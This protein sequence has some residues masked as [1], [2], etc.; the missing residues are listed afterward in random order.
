MTTATNSPD[1]E[2]TTPLSRADVAD[3]LGPEAVIEGICHYTGERSQ[4]GYLLTKFLVSMRDS[5]NRSEFERAPE[6]YMV[7]CG[8][9]DIEREMISL[10]DYDGMLEYGASIY[11]LGKASGALGTT[12]LEIGAKSRQQSVADFLTQRRLQSKD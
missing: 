5:V 1:K 8:L 2:C 12:L 7:K 4:R 10:R 11:A 6:A 9:S 3:A